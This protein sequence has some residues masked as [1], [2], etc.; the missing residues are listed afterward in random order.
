MSK[1]RRKRELRRVGKF[2]EKKREQKEEKKQMR[3]ERS[4]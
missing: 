4:K 1:E 2:L 3:R